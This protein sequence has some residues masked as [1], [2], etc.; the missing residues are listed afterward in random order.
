MSA[1]IRGA[2]VSAIRGARSAAQM[3]GFLKW[4]DAH[5]Q[6]D[7]LLW[8]RSLFAIWDIEDLI[9]ID[10]PWWTV[11]A[12]KTIDN[13][14]RNRTDVRVFEWGS[15]A[16][17]VWLSKR[18][19]HVISVEH[20]GRWLAMVQEHFSKCS[21]LKLLYV[22]AEH[23]FAH[24]AIHSG[25]RGWKG[26]D[27]HAYVS[28]IDGIQGDLDLIIIDGR[29][30]AEC[31]MRARTR[32]KQDGLIVFDNSSRARYQ[33]AIRASGL[34]VRRT[35]PLT[36]CLPYPDFTTLLSHSAKVLDELAEV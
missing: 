24:T 4:L 14:L 19:A 27:F 10:C 26:V 1:S 29:C 15:G 3:T 21:N 9:R 32:L 28:A 18:A 30:R 8:V 36:L 35:G 31:L 17:T 13:F 23:S 22:P 16:S 20:D 34:H 5:R 7:L 2:Y 6:N 11:A 33:A 25:K 12:T